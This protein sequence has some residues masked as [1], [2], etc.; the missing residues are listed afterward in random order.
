M[1]QNKSQQ[2]N[3]KYLDIKMEEL[4]KYFSFE[5]KM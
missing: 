1:K 5:L 4:Q 3:N 2:N